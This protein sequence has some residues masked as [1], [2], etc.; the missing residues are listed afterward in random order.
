MLNCM[1]CCYESAAVFLSSSGHRHVHHASEQWALMTT[2]QMLLYTVN[3]TVI[4]I[5]ILYIWIC[6]VQNFRFDQEFKVV[7]IY[8]E[9]IYLDE[10]LN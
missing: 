9:R 2:R 3:I 1:C 7:F 5:T 6:K 8:L 4:I 10:N